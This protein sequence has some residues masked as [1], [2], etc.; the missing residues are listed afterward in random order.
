MELRVQIDHRVAVTIAVSDPFDDRRDSYYIHVTHL[1]GTKSTG[2][3]PAAKWSMLSLR[4]VDRL[5]G[6]VRTLLAVN[7]RQDLL[8]AQV[9]HA[10]VRGKHGHSVIVVVV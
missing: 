9:S 3:G 7:Y 1:P 4:R 5:V 10:E 2:N 8:S 6:G